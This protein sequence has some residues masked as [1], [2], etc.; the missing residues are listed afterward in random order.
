[1]AFNVSNF[2]QNGLNLG[3]ARPSLFD[4]S[5]I[6]PTLISNAGVA[7]QKVNYACQAAELPAA[8]IGVIEVPYFG[9]KIKTPGDRTYANWE[10]TFQN[11]EDF[12]L[13]TAFESWSNYINQF[14]GNVRDST[15]MTETVPTAAGQAPFSYNTDMTVTQY[16]KNGDSLRAYNV[17]GAWPAEVGNIRLGWDLTNQIEVF[18]VTFAYDWWEP[19]T[20]PS[21]ASFANIQTQ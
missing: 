9:R 6:F 5:L 18:T 19:A 3:G 1:M 13:K 17:V 11:D 12:A 7:G 4:V 14:V 16:S 10:A 8:T 21:S 15:M 2:Q 20:T